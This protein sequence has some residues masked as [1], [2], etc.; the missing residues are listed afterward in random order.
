MDPY[1]PPSSTPFGKAYLISI[2]I[3]AYLESKPLQRLWRERSTGR[4]IGRDSLVF[5]SMSRSNDVKIWNTHT[6]TRLSNC[7]CVADDTM[8]THIDVFLF[9]NPSS[10]IGIF[11]QEEF[12]KKTKKISLFRPIFFLPRALFVHDR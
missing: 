11:V 9:S 7:V 3:S 2:E 8:C 5:A 10:S 6:T 4:D 12:K 1:A